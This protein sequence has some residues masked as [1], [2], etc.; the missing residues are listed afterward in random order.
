MAAIAASPAAASLP[1]ERF[2]RL[3]LFL[4]ILTSVV[5][6]VSTGKLE[7]LSST[8]APAAVLYKG[9]RWWSGRPAELSTRTATWM[10]LAYLVVFPFDVLFFSRVYVANSSNPALFAALLG[11]VHF[12]LF[13][14][15]VRLYSAVSDRDALFLA[16]LSFAALLASAVLTVDTAFLVLFFV[17]L[18]FGVATFVA[19]ELRRG[20]RGALLP[21]SALQPEHERRLNRSLSLAA[22]S[23]AV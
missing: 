22:L 6:V 14:M 16:M 8:L 20:A 2:F 12:L 11:A 17:F 3:S 7:L 13:V 10:V 19:M 21:P 15:L 4:L 18:L 23:V 1:A 5:T 9:F